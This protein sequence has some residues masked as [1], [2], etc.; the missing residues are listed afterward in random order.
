MQLK[1][2]VAIIR[3][4]DYDC[5]MIIHANLTGAGGHL[6]WRHFGVVSADTRRLIFEITQLHSAPA[7]SGWL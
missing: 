2:Y 4:L 1:L 6:R 7:C 5:S 3:H